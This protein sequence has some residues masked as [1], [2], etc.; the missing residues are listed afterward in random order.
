M[1]A[2]GQLLRV[3]CGHPPS[4]VLRLFMALH[5]FCLLRF[6]FLV[7]GSACARL[8]PYTYTPRDLRF[9]NF[10]MLRNGVKVFLQIVSPPKVGVHSALIHHVSLIVFSESLTLFFSA[11]RWSPLL[12]KQ[13]QR[14]FRIAVLRACKCNC[15]TNRLK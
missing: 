6:V 5:A 15:Y 3:V 10:K 9:L 4:H 1:V 14:V 7:C 2:E 8:R 13:F 12:L 11:S